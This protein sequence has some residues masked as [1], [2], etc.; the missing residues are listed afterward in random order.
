MPTAVVKD[1]VKPSG[2][3]GKVAPVDIVAI[4]GDA[5][6]GRV[7]GDRGVVFGRVKTVGAIRVPVQVGDTS[8][9][10]HVLIAIVNLAL[11]RGVLGVVVEGGVDGLPL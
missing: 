4:Q 3:L 9:L 7:G 10:P 5:N 6:E 1:S 11:F 2:V 8:P